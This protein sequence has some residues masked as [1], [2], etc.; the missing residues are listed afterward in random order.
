MVKDLLVVVV[1]LTKISVER[2]MILLPVGKLNVIVVALAE[3]AMA[4]MTA[5]RKDPVPLLLILV[6]TKVGVWADK[7]PNRPNISKMLEMSF[8]I[9]FIVEIIKINT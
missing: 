5:W 6:T 7:D 2:V 4:L 9:I 8:M 1:G 3:V